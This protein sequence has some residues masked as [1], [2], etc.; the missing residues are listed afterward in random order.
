MVSKIAIGMHTTLLSQLPALS[1]PLSA[2][3][4]CMILSLW[5]PVIPCVKSLWF[6]LIVC[7]PIFSHFLPRVRYAQETN[8]ILQTL[9]KRLISA[10]KRGTTAKMLFAAFD[11][12]NDGK[13]ISIRT[14]YKLSAKG[15]GD[16]AIISGA[17]LEWTYLNCFLIFNYSN[18]SLIILIMYFPLIY[19]SYICILCMY[20][21]VRSVSRSLERRWPPS[22]S[23]PT[24]MYVKRLSYF[25]MGQ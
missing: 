23:H 4:L 2:L 15:G 9:R 5:F 16:A 24:P 25:T 20:P 14:N 22:A 17:H 18:Y 12:N 19:V 7:K 13:D 21:Q 8:L 3:T 11:T 6:Q 1:S 10:E